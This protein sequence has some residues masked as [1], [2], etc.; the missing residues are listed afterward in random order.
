MARRSSRADRLVIDGLSADDLAW[1]SAESER[2]GI[3]IP[4]L[5]RAMIRRRVPLHVVTSD[6][7]PPAARYTEPEFYDDAVLGGTIELD[8]SLD[9]VMTAGPG[10]FDHPAD[11]KPARSP[12]AASRPYQL[13]RA[14][15]ATP[16]VAGAFSAFSL[17]KPVGLSDRVAHA[18]MQGDGV[19]NVAKQNNT[20]LGFSNGS[21]RG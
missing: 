18:P 10:L 20:W 21:R 13:P 9:E 6:D 12:R 1:L 3:D 4:N 7:V 14:P 2:T 5:V 8:A 19:G 16:R 11:P 15:V 17:V